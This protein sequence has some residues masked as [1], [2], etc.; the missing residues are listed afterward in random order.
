M[1]T[2]K[3]YTIREASEELEA[4]RK[5]AMRL[6]DNEEEQVQKRR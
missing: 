2:V 4:I 3:I 1:K 5:E 6:P